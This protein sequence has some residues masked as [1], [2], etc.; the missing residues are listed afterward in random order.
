MT[1]LQ[2]FT[3]GFRNEPGYLDFGRVG[4]LSEVV[5]AE[6]LGQNEVLSRARFGSLDHLA[7]QDLRART[8]VSALTGFTPDQIVL[9]P[10]TSSGLMQ[11][12]FGLT[13]SVL[14]SAGDFPS[15]PFAA[16]RAAETLH[17]VTPLWLET[18]RGR[19]TPGQIRDQLTP[20]VAAVAVCLVDSRTGYRADL[21]GIRQVIG[22]RLLIVDAIQGFGVVDTAFE[23]ADVVA[24]GGQKWTRAGWGTGFLAL[25]ERALDRLVPVYSGYVGTDTA[26]PWDEVTPPSHSARAFRVTNGD[27][28]AQARFAAALEQVADVGVDV[29]QAAIDDNVSQI[30]ELVDEFVIDL[31]SPRDVRER[32]GIVVLEPPAELLTT[33]VA[34]LHNHGITAT[35]RG[36]TV[37][38][39]VHAALAPDTVT[40]LRGALTAYA[41]TATY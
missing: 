3:D 37:R 26:E 40:M 23:A 39:S 35:T 20:A 27:A 8:A 5:M 18:E 13:G 1:S 38:L 2:N 30:I 14:L 10:N 19:V 4:P 28:I 33:L 41:L 31:V 25:S 36:T 15:V 12:M 6:T 29:I 34:S 7:E 22:D 24:S 21:D 32:A 17:V 11:T 9:Q 16:V